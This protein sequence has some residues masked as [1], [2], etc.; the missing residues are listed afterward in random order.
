MSRSPA[1]KVHVRHVSEDH[2]SRTGVTLD[3]NKIHPKHPPHGDGMHARASRVESGQVQSHNAGCRCIDTKH[4]HLPASAEAQLKTPE[5]FPAVVWPPP[6][7]LDLPLCPFQ[8]AETPLSTQPR[9]HL[10]DSETRCP[11]PDRRADAGPSL[12]ISHAADDQDDAGLTGPDHT[13]PP[14]L[15]CV[16]PTDAPSFASIA[17]PN[18]HFD[19]DISISRPPPALC[20]YPS[21]RQGPRHFNH[22]NSPLDS[23]ARPP[24]HATRRNFDQPTG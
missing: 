22:S 23:P 11:R 7:P 9:S 16:S 14:H 15:R 17:E 5:S 20:T 3:V 13:Q 6:L 24:A 4:G 8:T 12:S 2:L 10:V 19:G 18:A 21:D 1:P